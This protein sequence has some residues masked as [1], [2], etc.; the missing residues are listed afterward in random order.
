VPMGEAAGLASV[1]S[2][3]QGVMPHEIKWKDGRP[4]VS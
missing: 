3:R 4:A 2:L 1:A